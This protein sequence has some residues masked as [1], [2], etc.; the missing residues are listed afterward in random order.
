MARILVAGAG[1]AGCTA[2][3]T[4]AKNNVDVILIEKTGSIGG[5]SRGY[6]CKAVEKCQNCGVCLT[7]GLW[8]NVTNHPDIRIEIHSVIKDI[9]GN[10]GAFK[11]SITNLIEPNV[12]LTYTDIDSIIICTGFDSNMHRISSH[13]HVDNTT[14]I[15]T[16]TQLENLMLDRS[17]SGLFD[18]KPRSIAFIQCVSSRDINE[19]GLYCSRVCCSYST[20][21]A[22]VIHK[23]YPDCKIVFFYM[24]LQ[25][26]E[27]GDYYSGLN[28]LGIEFIKCRPLK[29][30]GGKPV[31]VEYDDPVNGI[32]ID[33]FDLVVLSNGIHADGDNEHLAEICGFDRDKDGFLHVIDE[34]SGYYIAGCARGPVKI[35]EAYADAVT[36]AGKILSRLSCHVKQDIE[37]LD[38]LNQRGS[39]PESGV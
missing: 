7:A 1:I 24:E 21:S 36:I 17:A 26:V 2:A 38:S 3:Y 22:K 27:A 32:Q 25:N 19:N 15:I 31:I 4:L 39:F 10:P 29:V 20:R 13:L 28:E 5:N 9:R 18:E 12:E 16:G 23:Y 37:P 8:N 11:V 6:G 34:S 35:E 14:G 33:E 30:S